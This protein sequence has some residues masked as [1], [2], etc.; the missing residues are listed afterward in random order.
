MNFDGIKDGRFVDGRKVLKNN[1][2]I[3]SS[4][5]RQSLDITKVILIK[6]LVLGHWCN[7]NGRS[8][9]GRNWVKIE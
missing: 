7:M 1:G 5:I 8:H 6:V 3:S 9:K 4:V 2:V